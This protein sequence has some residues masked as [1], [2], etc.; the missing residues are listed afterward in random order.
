MS[1][2]VLHLHT[3]SKALNIF[4]EQFILETAT[5]GIVF[6][7]GLDDFLETAK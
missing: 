2:C 7:P 6:S 5:G 1:H 3:H 4:V